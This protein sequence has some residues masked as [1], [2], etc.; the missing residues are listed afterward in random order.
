MKLPAPPCD[1][2]SLVVNLSRLLTRNRIM[3]SYDGITLFCNE[4]PSIERLDRQAAAILAIP[5]PSD[6]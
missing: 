3:G 4:L 6:D 1:Y 5:R 2:A